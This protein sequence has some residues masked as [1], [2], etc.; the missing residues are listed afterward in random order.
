MILFTLCCYIVYEQALKSYQHDYIAL[1][2][3][4]QKLRNE[5]IH[6]IATQKDLIRQINSQNDPAWIEWMLM[7]EL[8][9][10]PEG[11]TKVYFY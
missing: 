7:Q 4:L 5:K 11:Q 8:G 2:D 1:S 3:Q 6:A 9:L 10:T